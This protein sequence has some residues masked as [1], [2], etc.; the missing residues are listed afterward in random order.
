MRDLLDD[1]RAVLRTTPGRWEA[2]VRGL[3][4]DLL[5]RLPALGEWSALD[6]LRHLVEAEKVV[7]RVR[8]TCFLSG[9]PLADFN[10]ERQ[11]LGRR[12]RA[13]DLAVEFTRQRQESLA[14]LESL[15]PEDLERTAGH[16]R[17]GR[18]TL[19]QMLN[20]WAAH[21]LMHTVQ[22]ERSLMQHFLPGTGPWRS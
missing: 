15:G 21:D 18:V 9:K 7:F 6:C 11:G 2:L 19:R 1:V 22:A 14:L 4:A 5:E 20:E 10:P 8:A 12:G 17:L 13:T 3:P 16:E